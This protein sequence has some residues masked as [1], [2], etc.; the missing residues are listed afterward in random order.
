MS[1][2]APEPSRCFSVVMPFTLAERSSGAIEWR[3]NPDRG[4]IARFHLA[5]RSIQEYFPLDN[6]ESFLVIVPASQVQDVR[7]LVE[8]SCPGL[9]IEVMAESD[10]LPDI[11]PELPGW[12]LQQLIKLAASAYFSGRYYL[13]LDSDIIC[14]RPFGFDDLVVDDRAVMNLERVSDYV[15]LYKDEGARREV[16]VK[17]NRYRASAKLL[18]YERDTGAHPYFFGETPVMLNRAVVQRMLAHLE[19]RHGE[20]WQALLSRER[21]WTEYG[22][23]FQFLEAAGELE[24]F[25]QPAGC[26]TVLDLERSVWQASDWYRQ[27]RLYDRR[28]FCPA[29]PGGLFIAIQSWIDSR[30]WLPLRYEKVEAFYTDLAGFLGLG[31]A[32]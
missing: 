29:E 6:L 3:T 25:H 2:E 5:L 26:N 18:G 1:K 4:V 15:A 14:T 11:D 16:E 31:Q 30:H 20:A 32:V 10:I 22:L 28:H 8:Q 27:P 17:T 23:Y 9:G 21:K 19:K 24:A 7:G 12:Y 13:T